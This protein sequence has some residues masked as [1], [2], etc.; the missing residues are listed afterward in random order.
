MDDRPLFLIRRNHDGTWSVL[1]L[2]EFV[3]W[4][5]SHIDIERA[6]NKMDENAMSWS[7]ATDQIVEWVNE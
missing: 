2:T 3:L 5:I 1:D 4:G 7:K 6:H